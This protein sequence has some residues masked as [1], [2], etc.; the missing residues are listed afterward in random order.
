MGVCPQHDLLLMP[1][2]PPFFARD[3]IYTIMGVCPQHD[4]LWGPL[5]AR[6]HLRFYGR[7]KNLRGRPLDEAVDALLRKVGPF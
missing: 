1:P 2:P 5:T 6:E 3:G 4:L 7:L